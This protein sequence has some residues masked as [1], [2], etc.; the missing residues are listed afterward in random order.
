MNQYND[1]YGRW[2]GEGN[3]VPK[4]GNFTKLQGVLAFTSTNPESGGLEAV[5]GFQNYIKE[6][7]QKN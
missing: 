1:W 3:F 7:C 4:V 2:L 6:W 5:C